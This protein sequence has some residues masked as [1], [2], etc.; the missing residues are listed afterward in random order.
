MHKI[1]YF[2]NQ[3]PKGEKTSTYNFCERNILKYSISVDRY[4]SSL[5]AELKSLQVLYLASS[6]RFNTSHT[7]KQYFYLYLCVTLLFS[8]T[9]NDRHEKLSKIIGNNKP[10]TDCNYSFEEAT[11]GTKAPKHILDQLVLVDVIYYSTDH[12]LHQ[13]QIL[14]NKSIEEDTKQMFDFM[15]EQKFPIAKVIP[16][17]KYDWNDDSSMQDNNSSGFCYRNVGYSMHAR[18]LAIDIN[19]YFNPVIWKAG[20]KRTNKPQGAVYSPERAGTFTAEHPVVL[21]F[22]KLGFH[23]GGKFSAKYDYHHF[24]KSGYWK[25]K[26]L[27][28]EEMVDSS[29]TVNEANIATPVSNTPITATT[30]AIT[31][32]KGDE[33]SELPLNLI[34]T[35][36]SPLSHYQH[37]QASEWILQTAKESGLN[38]F[39]LDILENKISPSTFATDAILYPLGYLKYAL[40]K[41]LKAKKLEANFVSQA[42][43]EFIISDN[44]IICTAIVTDI[45]NQEYTAKR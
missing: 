15:L 27:Q 23:W 37:K 9:K 26:E 4:K 36:F 45:N 18:G 33:L 21:E 1:C 17:V 40:N 22:E 29:T 39:K 38:K 5:S 14:V 20:W 44:K 2:L 35:Y 12:K 19:P 32:L 30:K 3:I 42:Y 16:V 31:G 41:H 24:E 8:C 43:L 28:L 25:P 34:S 6:F 11:T 13:G 10:I 7:M